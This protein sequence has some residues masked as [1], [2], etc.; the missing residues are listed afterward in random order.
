MLVSPAEPKPFHALGKVSLRTEE[1]GCDF[2]IVSKNHGLVGVQRKTVDDLIASIQNDTRFAKELRQVNGSVDLFVLLLEGR[3]QWTNDGKLLSKAAFSQAQL[4]GTLW[5][6]Q[7]MGF[8]IAQTSSTTES[9]A[10]LLLFPRWLEKSKHRSLL[11]RG[12]TGINREVG[13]DRKREYGI[14]LLQGFDGIGYETAAAIYDHH[15][16]VPL[17]WTISEQELQQVKGIGKGRAKALWTAL[18]DSP[19]TPPSQPPSRTT[20]GRKANASPSP[21]EPYIDVVELSTL[22]RDA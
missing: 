18:S 16:G 12:K 6:M 4:Y 17:K 14:W 15:K 20:S 5:S 8:W 1:L 13:I 19:S 21:T 3:P 2:L 11:D 9:I 10:W 22:T 7:S